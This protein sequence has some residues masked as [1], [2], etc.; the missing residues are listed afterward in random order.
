MRFT[1]ILILIM[2]SLLLSAC[3]V[4][5]KAH[6]ASVSDM[7]IEPIPSNG[8][9]RVV[10][11]ETLY[12]I[13]W[14]YGLD[15]R[16]LANQNGLV[17]PYY[18][19]TGQRIYLRGQSPHKM[20]V[21]AAQPAMLPDKEPTAPVKHWHWPAHGVV[22]GSFTST[23]RGINIE[24]KAG[25]P[26]YAAADGKVV[27]SGN[28]LR[29]YGNLI[30]IKHNSAFLTAYANNKLV[31]VREGEWVRSGQ[32]IAEMGY[33]GKKHITLHFEI[34]RNGEPVNPMQYF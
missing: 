32:K 1:Q 13:A 15:Y 21:A 26:V 14:R 27:Y 30:I 8:I 16:K 28:R 2:V 19:K 24:G 3:A 18:V 12:S 34:R 31:F 5:A 11:G 25:D 4:N 6:Y 7:R 17:R 22:V 23:N 20:T 10:H 29:D 33:T 9:H